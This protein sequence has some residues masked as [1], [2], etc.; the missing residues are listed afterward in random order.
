MAEVLPGWQV[1]V[2]LP[3]RRDRIVVRARR[4]GE[5][6]VVVKATV[7]GASWRDRAVLRREGRL[8]DQARGPGLVELLDVVD[9][10]RRTALVLRHLPL[11]SAPE[12]DLATLDAVRERLRR[13]GF[14][15]GEPAPEH[16]RRTADGEP[17]LCSLGDQPR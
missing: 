5:A 8:L 12:V 10:R 9:T 1:D 15:L 11:P 6:P 3:G 17:V 2:R 7:P 4:D 14:V 16:V 13:V